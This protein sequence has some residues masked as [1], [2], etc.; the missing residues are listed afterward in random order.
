[1]E[2]TQ[3]IY[4]K[5]KLSTTVLPLGHFTDPHPLSAG[6]LPKGECH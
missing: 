2:I 1:M 3:I 5:I 6:D 4:L